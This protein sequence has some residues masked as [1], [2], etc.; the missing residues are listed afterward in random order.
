MHN[1]SPTAPAPLALALSINDC[2]SFEQLAVIEGDAAGTYLSPTIIEWSE[3]TVKLAYSV[4]GQGL[5]LATV[6]LATVEG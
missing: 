4:G 6:K 3:D 1:P 2:R 5:K